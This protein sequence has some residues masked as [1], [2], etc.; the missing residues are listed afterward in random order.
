MK[1]PKGESK[2]VVLGNGVVGEKYLKHL[3]AFFRYAEKMG[4][5]AKLGL[6]EKASQAAYQNLKQIRGEK[7]QDEESLQKPRD[8]RKSRL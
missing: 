4:Y 3:K 5:E 7:P 6:A 1:T 8:L 2:Q